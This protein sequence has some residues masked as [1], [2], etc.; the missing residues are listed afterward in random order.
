MTLDE[1]IK[2]MNDYKEGK[3]I[4]R[5][6]RFTSNIESEKIPLYNENEPH[7]FD[8]HYYAY[9]LNGITWKDFSR[10]DAFNYRLWNE[11]DTACDNAGN[12]YVTSEDALKL[13]N[14]GIEYGKYHVLKTSKE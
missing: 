5:T 9:A 14:D 11:Y 13:F 12:K 4:Y 6:R 10:E 2:I 3:Q 8:F 7:D 1:Q